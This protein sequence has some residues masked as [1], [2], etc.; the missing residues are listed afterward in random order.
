[1]SFSSAAQSSVQQ[2]GD[3][4][5]GNPLKQLTLEQLGNIEVTTVSK[6]PETVRRTP[7]AIYVITA[8]DIRQS[9][10]RTLP[11]ILRLAPGVEVSQLDSDK[12][13]VGIRGFEGRLSRSVLVLIDGR[14]VYT[15]LFAGVYWEV[16][17]T[18]IED[19]D[20]I[21]V[22]RGPGGTIWGSN[23]V[24]GVINIITKNA[25]DTRGAMVSAGGGNVE[26]GFMDA[27]YGGGGNSF[28]YRV[29]AKGFTRGP[30]Y[31]QTGREF[32]DWRLGQ[33]GFRTDWDT[34]KR[35]TLT[36]QGDAY[37][38]I[39]GQKLGI[40]FYS[41]PSLENLEANGYFSGEN[42][43][44]RWRRVL[45]ASSDIQ[46]QAYYDR[47][48]R[49]DLNYREVRNT[50]DIDF[51]HH[52]NL[53]R[54]T[55][56]WGAGARISPSRFFQKYETVDF[57]PHEQTYS[58]YSAFAQDEIALVP[59]VL[60]F[61]VGTKLEHNSFSGF[62]VQPSGRL[63][64]TPNKHNSFWMA[65]TRAVRTP[66]RIEQGF[67]FTALILPTIPGYVRLIGDGDFSPEQLLG[68]EVGYRGYVR[69]NFS[70]DVAAFYNQYNDLLS[71][72]NPG[73]VVET[74]P[75][76]PHLLIPLSLRNGVQAISKGFEIS[77]AWRVAAWW[78]LKGSYSFLHLN[79][80]DKPT[81]DDASTVG[82][83]QGDSPRHKV[84]VQSLFNLPR[85]FET[86]FTYRYVSSINDP[87]QKVAAYSTADAR[88]S[89]RFV[90]Q[91]EISLVGRNLFQ[92]QHFE[93]FG[94]PGG[95]VGIKRSFYAQLTWTR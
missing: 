59:H 89:W 32:D 36:I 61:T 51:I 1:M 5:S 68:Y 70:V 83:L 27:R 47:T 24:N 86:D 94:D 46:L 2:P 65:A 50:F 60:S 77:P 10:A 42:V 39:A 11:D 12:W 31:H 9:G 34:S 84:V 73:I 41:P 49:N 19:I 21:E 8:E 82:Q 23:A 3:Q 81:S 44:G 4:T 62:D 18:L 22:I 30:E 40:S 63:L 37:S 78:N 76:P 20:R 48:D 69:D 52:I 14:S 54:H 67:Q 38:E 79:A 35:D 87:G 53:D 58:I 16:Q 28:N 17:S 33:V 71:V 95:P 90:P 93:Y 80:R 91:W 15:P 55:F 29:Y 57:I 85:H 66:S 72:E 25:K 92:P 88:L 64:W 7:A 6:E 74:S 26:Q 56:I 45:N 13:A 43:V 75:P